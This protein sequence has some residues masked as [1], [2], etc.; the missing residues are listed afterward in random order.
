MEQLGSHWTQYL[1]VFWKSVLKIEVPLKSAKNDGYCTCRHIYI[2]GSIS[3][4]SYHNEKCFRKIGREHEKNHTLCSKFFFQKSHNFW[5][6]VE[7]YDL[8]RQATDD[9]MIRHMCFA[10]WTTKATNTHLEYIILNAFLQWHWIVLLLR[11]MYIA[12]LDWIAA[13]VLR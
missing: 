1:S 13:Y 11:C 12:C 7:K 3:L 8:A 5:D 2:Y 10:C 6:N 9:S 4:N